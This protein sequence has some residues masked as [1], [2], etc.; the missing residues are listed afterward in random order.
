MASWNNLRSWLFGRPAET[1][2]L[3]VLYDEDDILDD[4]DLVYEH[5]AVMYELPAL[6]PAD[7]S[8][9][10][11]FGAQCK[12][13]AESRH[14]EQAQQRLAPK[15]Q[16]TR[17]H[18]SA[19][20][21]SHPRSYADLLGRDNMYSINYSMIRIIAAATADLY[22]LSVRLSVPE[23]LSA[24]F[25]IHHV[26]ACA[27]LVYS[28]CVSQ[29]VS[30]PSSLAS[31]Q[32]ETYTL[33]N[34]K[35]VVISTQPAPVGG[36]PNVVTVSFDGKPFTPTFLPT[37]GEASTPTVAT[38]TATASPTTT[39]NTTTGKDSSTP[40]EIRLACRIIPTKPYTLR[41]PV[42]E[43]QS[44]LVAVRTAFRPASR[45]ITVVGMINGSKMTK[46]WSSLFLQAD[47]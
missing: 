31:V 9:A 7:A 28:P 17:C 33:P 10:D 30:L 25:A 34:G 27:L 3:E 40:T 35:V 4:L 5:D 8:P 29:Q 39:G 6:L 44:I 46:M 13:A 19:T 2:T 21:P 37:S 23:I 41:L 15:C 47:D 12:N 43:Y 20:T 16:P 38:P 18:E 14:K 11:I 45:A 26:A 32:L 42:R 1:R 36:F 22:L 24:A